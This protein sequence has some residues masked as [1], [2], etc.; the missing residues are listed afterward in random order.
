MCVCV[1]V[2]GG[3]QRGASKARSMCIRVGWRYLFGYKMGA[4]PSNITADM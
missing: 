1:C 4:N 3:G 2:E